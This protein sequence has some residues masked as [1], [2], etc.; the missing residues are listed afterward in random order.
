MWTNTVALEKKSFAKRQRPGSLW[1]PN[2]FV[3]LVDYAMREEVPP[4]SESEPVP[5]ER[6]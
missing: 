3:P 1:L 6:F 5:E 2:H 4:S